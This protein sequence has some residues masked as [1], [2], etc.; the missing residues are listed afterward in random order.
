MKYKG[1]KLGTC[2][3]V[4]AKAIVPTNRTDLSMRPAT[5]LSGSRSKRDTRPGLAAHDAVQSRLLTEASLVRRAALDK[6]Y[7]RAGPPM[8]GVLNFGNGRSLYPAS[9]RDEEL[10][11]I[12]GEIDHPYVQTTNRAEQSCPHDILSGAASSY[13]I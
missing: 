4:H 5:A 6:I 7:G 2:S 13:F 10:I 3:V 9:F 11:K 12:M 1:E 8:T